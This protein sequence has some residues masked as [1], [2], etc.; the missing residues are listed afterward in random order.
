MQSF[1]K[2]LLAKAEAGGPFV[3]APASLSRSPQCL[4]IVLA[5]AS[6]GLSCSAAEEELVANGS[7]TE[8]VHNFPTGWERTEDANNGI[9]A[10]W[11]IDNG[12]HSA[13][14]MRIECSAFPP[15][16]D[17]VPG[18]HVDLFQRGISLLK[19]E[20]YVVSF[21]AKAEGIQPRAFG[22]NFSDSSSRLQPELS[23]R[24]DLTDKWQQ[25]HL[26]FTSKGDIPAK[27]ALLRFT[28]DST[29]TIW[30]DDISLR[31]RRAPKASEAE[32]PRFQPRVPS[33]AAKNLIPN[34]SFECG[35]SGWLS[36]GQRLDYGG[37]L[38]GLYGTILTS[39]APNG[40]HCYQLVLGPGA[41]PES[42]FDCWPPQHLTQ[43]RLLVANEGWIDVEPG[44]PY[45]L[46][47]FMRASKAGI[48]G[49]LQLNFSGDAREGVQA[50]RK[51]FELGVSWKRY[52]FTVTAP[53]GS[54]YVAVGPDVSR[55]PNEI[56][57]FWADAV[58]LE[59]GGTPSSFQPHESLE[60]G[61]NSHKDGN[62]FTAG[63]PAGIEVSGSNS[64]R[65][66]LA[67]K[68]DIELEDFWDQPFLKRT[69]VMSVAA[70]RSVNRR[71]DLDIPPGYYR[72]KFTWKEAG[73]A[74]TQSMRLAVIKHYAF[75]DS[76][77]GLN[78]GPATSKA[79]QK[80][81]EAGITWIRDWS[82]NWEWI[83]PQPGR[84]S[85]DDVDQQIKRIH[86]AG[87]NLLSLLPSN[88]STNWAS[89]APSAVEPTLWHRLA[90]APKDPDLLFRFISK[91]AGHY[92]GSISYWE[93]LNEPLWVPDFC[94]PKTAGYTVKT[95]VELLKG[96]YAAIHKA[97]PSAKVVG[98]LAIQS[99]LAFGD[100]FI[101][102]GGLAY[103][104][105]L[106]LHPYPGKRAPETFIADMERINKKMAQNGGPKPIWATETGYYGL[107]EFPFL[108]WTPPAE[109]FA[110]NRLLGSEQQ[111]ADY[112][113]RFS[114]ILL[115]SGVH[116]IFWHEPSTGE[117]NNALD[118]TENSFLAPGGNPRKAYVAIS[119]LANVLGQTPSFVCDWRS[120]CGNI[121]PQTKDVFGYAFSCGDH[122]TLVVWATGHTPTGA[123]WEV[124][125]PKQACA[126]N[127]AGTPVSGSKF[128][129]RESPIFITSSTL[130]PDQ[131][132]QRCVLEGQ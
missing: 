99:E 71:V 107:D 129:L 9:V 18:S 39:P 90:Y 26:E 89:E 93:F 49:V 43:K 73:I 16:N 101:A 63:Q 110:A 5:I 132:A 82:V 83:E 114:T 31:G 46:S 69:L 7:F 23:A 34:G 64:S 81:K 108:P 80:L 14:S 124:T 42:Y 65:Q 41:T 15:P 28:L 17:A 44:R 27:D 87:F 128:W 127:T 24:M 120:P 10:T 109:Y 66:T 115:A 47:A 25:Y 35:G 74:H 84:L 91:A 57:T 112:I 22:V 117:A 54:V 50:V 118:D 59:A 33:T 88:P 121:S 116:K 75:T 37:N 67:A 72:A 113:V 29:G 32:I 130:R 38:A 119:A 53:K 8:M 125:I 51:E 100:E 12:R 4:V 79:C 61:F 6:L 52:D 111:C 97:N 86:D 3:A 70:Y 98:G 126:V 92:Q 40:D 60:F 2:H 106:N 55:N 20:H 94:L 62:I 85:F 45:T 105:I 95:Y 13:H 131:L 11:G 77:F 96:A 30:L 103:V 56:V 123:P 68:I 58:Q 1:P 21:W 76:P 78:H 102:A 48:T 36:L 19:G 122:S 104:D